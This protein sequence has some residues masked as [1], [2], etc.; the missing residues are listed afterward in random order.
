MFCFM[1]LPFI[2]S[3]LLKWNS[4]VPRRMMMSFWL[5]NSWKPHSA[6]MMRREDRRL[7]K[8]GIRTGLS[9]AA[10]D[11]VFL[12]VVAEKLHADYGINH[13]LA[14]LLRDKLLQLWNRQTDDREIMNERQGYPSIRPDCV[15]SGHR[16]VVIDDLPQPRHS[17]RAHKK[18][19]Q[20]VSVT[21]W[22]LSPHCFQNS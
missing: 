4:F 10:D 11:R 8:E 16:V 5:A 21:D 18:A 15:G 1:F 20:S 7:L 19:D 17:V 3:L 9:H 12:A 2:T 13:E 6:V 22:S 14:Q